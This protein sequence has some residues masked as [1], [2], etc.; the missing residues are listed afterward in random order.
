M[1]PTDRKP[2]GN[3]GRS[4]R[5]GRPGRP[6]GAAGPGFRGPQKKHQ[7]RRTRSYEKRM[8]AG[9]PNFVPNPNP[10]PAQTAP[11]GAPPEGHSSPAQ[12][13]SAPDFV[14]GRRPVFE[15]FQA[16]K[17]TIHKLWVVKGTGGGVVEQSIKLARERGIPI[18][19]TQ[20]DWLDRK[21]SGHH[22]GIVAQVS[23]VEYIELDEFLKTLPPTQ[24]ALVLA[25]D[26]IQDPQNLGAMLR[27]AGFFG[28]TAAIV[29][30]WRSAPV[31]DASMRVSS[32]AA[33]HVPMIRVRNLSDALLEMKREGFEIVCSDMSGPPAWTHRKT[34]RTVL[35][36]GNEGEGM[37][38]LVKERCDKLI[39]IP[40]RSVVDSLNVAA[41]TAIFLYEYF[42][43]A[44]AP[45]K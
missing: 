2:Q 29:P 18:E 13:E 36:L 21:V 6:G 12:D 43:G 41:A 28:V 15:V 16:A 32:G 35:V 30:R 33:E 31:S 24:D 38:R 19:W 25:L 20:H 22:Q 10:G 8:Q 14:F 17:R 5:F 37:R 26:E 3:S 9:N 11:G 23:A 4:T 27:S 45:E 40:R 39:G 44:P 7:G 34:A 42:R 1:R